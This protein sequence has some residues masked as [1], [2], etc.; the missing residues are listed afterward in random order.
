MKMYKKIIK[1][2]KVKFSHRKANKIKNYLH[3]FLYK[4]LIYFRIEELI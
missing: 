1:I 4:K 3:P 2:K